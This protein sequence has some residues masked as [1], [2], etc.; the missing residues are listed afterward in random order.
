MLNEREIK[1][2]RQ[3]IIYPCIGIASVCIAMGIGILWIL[4]V[5]LDDLAF[6]TKSFYDIGLYVYLGIVI[7]FMIV[8]IYTFSCCR[9]GKKNRKEWE[10]IVDKANV[11]LSN[12]DYTSQTAASVGL[13]A[14]GRLMKHSSNEKIKGLGSVSEIAGGAAAIATV[15]S[16][17]MEMHRNAIKVAKA[18]D[19]EIPKVKKYILCIVFIPMILLTLVYIPE[20]RNA[21]MVRQEYSTQASKN[22]YSIRDALNEGCFEVDYDDPFEEDGEYYDVYG[23]LNAKSSETEDVYIHIDCDDLGNITGVSYYADIDMTKTMQEN[24]DSI[25]ADFTQLNTLLQNSNAKALDSLCLTDYQFSDEFREQFL[26]G[27]YYQKIDLISKHYEHASSY[28]CFETDSEE[29]FDDYSNP[30]VYHSI[31]YK[32]HAQKTN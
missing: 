5:M 1:K 24:L 7:L 22:I 16:M 18:F 11:Q 2:I 4:L 32:K 9:F 3:R 19:L 17:G 25:E 6:K 15:S 27:S 10:E 30:Y 20:Y 23:Y 12:K 13:M 21:L 28:D 29:E 31:T 26:N 14:S 8:F